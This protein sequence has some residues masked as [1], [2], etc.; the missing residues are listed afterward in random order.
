MATTSH[1]TQSVRP[2]K[3]FERSFLDERDSSLAKT[4]PDS[5]IDGSSDFSMR[6]VPA[7][8]R[9]NFAQP[10][11][12][13]APPH[14]QSPISQYQGPSRTNAQHA[15]PKQAQVNAPKNAVTDILPYCT[16]EPPLRQEQV[17]ALSDIVGSVRELVILAVGA[18]AGD[19]AC[20][21]KMEAAVGAQTTGCIVEFFAGE[22]E[23]E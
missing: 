10:S 12:A 2:T 14:H 17:I 22:W 23:V 11:F 8:T 7:N 9:H 13:H 3:Y 18:A 19:G 4:I 16:T 21:D 5:H 15:P 1:P 6:N 20:A